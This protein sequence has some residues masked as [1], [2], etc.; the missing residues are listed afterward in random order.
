MKN[1]QPAV[2][3]WDGEVMR[4]TPVSLPLCMRQFVRGESY[5]LTAE[6]QRSAASHREFMALVHEA[7]TNLPE[8][9][10]ATFPTPDKLR[11]W[12]L[13]AEGFAHEKTILLQTRGDAQRVY[14]YLLEGPENTHAE[15][16][17][18]VVKVWTAKSQR[19]AAMHKQEFESAKE[20]VLERLAELIG[21]HPRELSK[22]AGRAA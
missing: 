12:C 11:Y 16:N 1:L 5:L 13:I 22:N 3:T 7:W 8:R 6:E 9:L 19:Y 17:G 21:V 14:E 18:N 15:I 4:P 10:E 20:A 2:F